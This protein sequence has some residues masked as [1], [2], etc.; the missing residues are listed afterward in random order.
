MGLAAAVLYVSYLNNNI[1]NSVHNK[2]NESSKNKV[3]Q[4]FFSRQQEKNIMKIKIKNII[5]FSL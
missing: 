2:N 5:F 1:N 4:A 3:S